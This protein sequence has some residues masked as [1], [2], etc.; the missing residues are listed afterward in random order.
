MIL[1]HDFL[2]N[3]MHRFPHKYCEILKQNNIMF[4]ITNCNKQDF[5]GKVKNSELFLYF[6]GQSPTHLQQ[7]RILISTI[8]LVLKTPCYPNWKT[9]WHFNDKVSQYYLLL[10]HSFPAV[11]SWIFWDKEEAMKW[12]SDAEYPVVF[13]LKGGAGSINVVKINSR[14]HAQNIIRLMFGMGIMDGGIPGVNLYSV[15]KRSMSRLYKRKVKNIFH[16]FGLR[17][18]LVENWDREHGYALFQKFLPNND[19]DTRVTV[20]GN[21]AFAYRRF[22]RP[23]DFRSSGSGNFEVSPEKIDIQT[24]KTSFEIS[25]KLGFLTMAYDWLKGDDGKPAINEM[26][27]QF[28]DWMVQSCPGYWDENLIWH[29]GHFWP[30]YIQLQ[31]ILKKEDFIQPDFPLYKGSDNIFKYK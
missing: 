20:I 4:E 16:Y 21:K 26:S 8:D 29:E 22:N 25:N 2:P 1:I 28:V 18:G 12:A 17:N 14:E 15:Y 11:E 27:C 9:A 31:H 10:S 30:Q 6:L 23:N 13:K 19:Y 7:Q 3:M 24:I 5:W